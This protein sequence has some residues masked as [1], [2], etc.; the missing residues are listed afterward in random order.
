MEG[1]ELH[2][3]FDPAEAIQVGLA[4]RLVAVGVTSV[5]TGLAPAVALIQPRF[6]DAAF[7]QPKLSLRWARRKDDVGKFLDF[8][9]DDGVSSLTKASRPISRAAGDRDPDVFPRPIVSKN[10]PEKIKI[11]FRLICTGF[12]CNSVL[13]YSCVVKF[14]K[15]DELIPRAVERSAK[16]IELKQF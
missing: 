8:L 4:D 6:R 2:G 16:R 13:G 5:K 7:A 1:V 11:H 10:L 14:S 3:T 12:K 15:A 9:A